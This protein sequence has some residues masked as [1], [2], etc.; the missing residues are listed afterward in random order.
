M[1][2]LSHS[3][4]GLA[5]IAG[6]AV[7]GAEARA[8]ARPGIVEF[9]DG[10]SVSGQVSLT[11]GRSLKLHV[12]DRVQELDLAAVREMRFAPEQES[13]E[14]KWRFPEAGQT[15]KEFVGLPCPVRS[16]RTTLVMGDD[17]AVSGHLYTTALYV[18]QTGRTDKVVLAAKQRGAEGQ[19]LAA[20]IYP[21][22]I[23]FSDSAGAD[24]RAAV[25]RFVGPDAPDGAVVAAITL[26]ALAR[27]P[28]RPAGAGRY[29]IPP[30]LGE[31]LLVGAHRGD[32]VFIG[33]PGPGDA[34]LFGAV[35]N[36][37][38]LAKDF[39]DEK[40]LLAVHRPD[41]GDAVYSLVLLARRG[42]T[43]L[44]AARSQPWQVAVLRWKRD[45]VDARLMLCGRG[46]FFRDIVGRNA[47]GP[48][49]ALRPDWWPVRRAGDNW[50]VGREP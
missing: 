3:A 17:Q 26:G 4:L 11:A 41:G 22:R 25:L 27:L 24:A 13:L 47:A 42:A 37:L 45:D 40:R 39:F 15:R 43:T 29:Q 49:V 31:E 32:R 1:H 23:A 50:T 9:S 34:A 10:S 2:A 33:W 38:A 20:L 7:A 36:A 21:A 14:R 12:K 35:S 18:E 8:A 6:I 16:L 44:G 19:D 5:L 48:D 46:Y 30:S 28:G